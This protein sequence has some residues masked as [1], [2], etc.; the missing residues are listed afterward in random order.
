M[1]SATHLSSRWEGLSFHR[2]MSAIP[3]GSI[4]YRLRHYATETSMYKLLRLYTSLRC[5]RSRG[6]RQ[7]THIAV[8]TSPRFAP[9]KPQLPAQ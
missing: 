1:A 8:L 4:N 5:H 2:R 7:P 3:P 9:V 6:R